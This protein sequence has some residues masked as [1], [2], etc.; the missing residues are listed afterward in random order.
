MKGE[1]RINQDKKDSKNERKI[2]RIEAK[3]INFKGI[4]TQN[5]DS[6]VSLMIFSSKIKNE[7]V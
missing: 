1:W 3:Y 7:W 5:E 2:K 6:H 4:W